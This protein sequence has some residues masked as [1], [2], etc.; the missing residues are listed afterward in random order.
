MI[1]AIV[2][3]A[4]AQADPT[5]T[6]CGGVREFYTSASCCDASGDVSI[7]DLSGICPSVSESTT[8]ARSRG[9]W[10]PCPVEEMSG[11]YSPENAQ[12]PGYVGCLSE[13]DASPCGWYDY[14][15][16]DSATNTCTQTHTLQTAT[17][18]VRGG[19]PTMTKDMLRLTK[20]DYI[21][22]VEFPG[23]PMAYPGGTNNNNVEVAELEVWY[24]KFLAY[25]GSE[26]DL[27][28]FNGYPTYGAEMGMVTSVA[29]KVLELA[30][31]TCT[32]TFYAYLEAPAYGYDWDQA[33]RWVDARASGFYNGAECTCNAAGTCQSAGHISIIQNG[34]AP[35]RY[36]ELPLAPG[37]DGVHYYPNSTSPNSPWFQT[38]V[39]PGNPIGRFH[40]CIAPEDRCL[41]DG[42]YWYPGFTA[43][44]TTLQNFKCYSWAFSITKI[45]SAQFR[46]GM[47]FVQ[48]TPDARS[49]G[50][51][52]FGTVLSIANGLMSYMQLHGQ[53]I[54]MSYM[55]LHGQAILMNKMMAEPFSSNTSWLHAMALAQYEKWDVLDEAFSVCEAAGIMK[56]VDEQQKYFGAYVFAHMMPDYHGLSANIGGSSSDFFKTVVGYDHFNYNWGW[57]G[58]DPK[59]YGVGENITTLD[60]HRIHLFRAYDVYAEEARRM[61]LVCGNK[62]AKVSSAFLSV[63]EWVALR[64]FEASNGRRRL[65]SRGSSSLHARALEIMKA[66]P[67]MDIMA[68]VTHAKYVEAVKEKEWEYGL[69]ADM[70]DVIW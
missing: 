42:V 60:F 17:Q 64:T 52:I 22:T 21:P 9:I 46:G 70:K 20:K 63:N 6:T 31:T 4:L 38:N 45:Y 13:D 26:L 3:F 61:K 59:Y 43:P 49:A 69:P 19:S 27:S 66:V 47:M 65:E 16:Y 10:D 57:R 56:R 5:V 48:N 44:G 24:K 35:A 34:W 68:A 51:S 55:Q 58:E 25:Y 40:A 15:S 1:G 39:I 14:W 36:P 62:D 28:S 29:T 54:L 32:R 12:A 11:G 37:D 18:T 23:L 8:F 67:S 2:S 33:V 41:C 50:N 7:T 53:V 30:R